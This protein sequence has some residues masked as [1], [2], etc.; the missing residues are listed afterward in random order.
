MNKFI[1]VIALAL[2]A[3]F[4]TTACEKQDYQITQAVI[5]M[6]AFFNRLDVMET[7]LLAGQALTREQIQGVREDV[8]GVRQ[9]VLE[10]RSISNDQYQDI[11]LMFENLSGVV[12]LGFQN[13]ENMRLEDRQLIFELLAEVAVLRNLLNDFGFD[14]AGIQQTLTAMD[15]KLAVMAGQQLAILQNQQTMLANQANFAGA[16]QQFYAQTNATLAQHGLSL[17]SLISSQA[18]FEAMYIAD[19][20]AAA[21]VWAQIQAELVSLGGSIQE[22]LQGIAALQTDVSY[23][24]VKVDQLCAAV[25]G[26]AQQLADLFQLGQQTFAGVNAVDASI[27]A[28]EQSLL[29]AYAAGNANSDMQFA[30]LYAYL[31]GQFGTVNQSLAELLLGQNNLANGQNSLSIQ[32]GNG[33]A[34]NQDFLTQMYNQ[35]SSQIANSEGNVINAITN[36]NGGG[37][38]DIDVVI[39]LLTDIL[40]Y[41][42]DWQQPFDN[43]WNAC[44]PV[45]ANDNDECIILNGVQINLT[46]SSNVNIDVGGISNHVGGLQQQNNC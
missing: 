5:P 32:I 40:H 22:G 46:N 13:M 10:N 3:S 28:L 1:L 24:R 20:A 4:L 14:I 45:V 19:Q 30:D 11:Q 31:G 43:C 15:A 26:F 42:Q 17:Q 21:A 16:A 44:E 7:T 35:L 34:G 41:V 2:G 27:S 33:F 29:A 18:A 12:S 6:E 8:A 25:P 37:N 9:E 38:V 39:D 36:N 23:I